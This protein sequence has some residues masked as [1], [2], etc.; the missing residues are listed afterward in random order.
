MVWIG[1][2]QRVVLQRDYS[3][4][5]SRR[6]TPPPGSS[7]LCPSDGYAA[8]IKSS[9]AKK[10]KCTVFDIEPHLYVD[11]VKNATTEDVISANMSLLESLLAVGVPVHQFAK[12]VRFLSDKAKVFTGSSLIHYDL[13][14][15]EKAELWGAHFFVYGDLELYHTYLGV[16]Q[17]KPNATATSPA[18]VKGS[19]TKR[20]ICWKKLM[21]KGPVSLEI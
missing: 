5:P 17:L 14:L 8:G 9:A 4:H 3:R 12:H 16:E 21:Q 20:G 7:I 6:G 13:P 15:G 19:K 11:N 10:R 1:H 18:Q 2:G